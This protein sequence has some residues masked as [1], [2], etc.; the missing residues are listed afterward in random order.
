MEFEIPEV[1]NRVYIDEDAE[2][3]MKLADSAGDAISDDVEIRFAFLDAGD[4]KGDEKRLGEIMNA[5][6]FN[7]LDLD[8]QMSD[9]FNVEVPL[10]KDRFFKE[11][12]R[13]LIQVAGGEVVDHSDDNSANSIIE[14][15]ASKVPKS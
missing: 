15:D 2:L 14:I 7:T 12:Q 10:E 9:E 8:Q 13:L 5:R 6:K 11:N 1:W 4:N 3:V